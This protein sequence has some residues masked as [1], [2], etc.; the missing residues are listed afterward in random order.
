MTSILARHAT[1]AACY[2]LVQFVMFCAGKKGGIG[3]GGWV[4]AWGA[5]FIAVALFALGELHHCTE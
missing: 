3:G 1:L 5:V 2:H 4:S